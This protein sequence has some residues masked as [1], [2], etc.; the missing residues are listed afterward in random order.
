MASCKVVGECGGCKYIGRPYHYQMGKKQEYVSKLF[1][2]ICDV[3][4]IIPCDEP[5]YYRNK[6]HA[7]FKRMRGGRIIYGTYAEGS[8][9]VIEHSKCYI[10]NKKAQKIIDDIAVLAA[11][12]KMSIY[13]EKT[14]RGLLRHVMVRVSDKTGQIMVVLVVGNK[15]FTGKKS[16]ID[17]LRNLHP[18]ITTVLTSF[19]ERRDSMVLG[20]SVRTEFGSGVIEEELFNKRFKLSAESFFQVN[21]PQAEHLYATVADLADIMPEHRI[22][23]CYC[24]TGTITIFLSDLCKEA[25]GV[26]INS[27]AVDNANR[28]KRLNRAGNVSFVCRDAT[29]YME[30]LVLQ[31]KEKID[32]VIIDPPRAGTT[33]RFINSCSTL[34]PD[35]IIYVSCNPETLLRDVK[36]FRSAGYKADKV[37]PVDMFPWTEEIECVC[38]L[39]RI[40]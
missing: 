19:N 17:D 7:A 27:A 15:Y 13:N 14:Y 31:G 22:L 23:D 32:T 6:V 40:N 26:E 4:L 8:H 3:D 33:V 20:N 29:D 36:L 11:K 37:V 39:K 9:R 1:E 10:E 34:A 25:T 38:R 35:R 18:E 24:G 5:Y 28:N 12:H 16:F 2:G 21:T 30:W